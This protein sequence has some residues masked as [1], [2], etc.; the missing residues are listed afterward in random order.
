[1]ITFFFKVLSIAEISSPP[2]LNIFGLFL[3][4]IIV[5]S[6]PIDDLPPSSTYL[7]FL[8]KSSLTLSE[9]T[10]LIFDDKL[11]LGAA[12][13]KNNFFNKFLVTGCFGNLTAK[14]FLLLVTIF[15]IFEFFFKSKINVIGPGPVSYTHLRAH[16]TR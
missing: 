5:D 16:E 2:N 3:I 7:I 15:E 4:S 1:M 11:A 12:K 8:P 9:Q 14:E 10:A 13:G 6:I